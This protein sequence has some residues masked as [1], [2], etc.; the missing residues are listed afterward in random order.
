MKVWVVTYNNRSPAVFDGSIPAQAFIDHEG[1][2]GYLDPE[3]DDIEV[4]ETSFFADDWISGDL[5]E[6]HDKLGQV[7]A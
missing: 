7:R 2:L 1:K 4:T 5:V 6:V 3:D